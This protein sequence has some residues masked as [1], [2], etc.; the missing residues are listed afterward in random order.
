MARLEMW[1]RGGDVLWDAQV[2]RVVPG[3]FGLS[4]V[5]RWPVAVAYRACSWTLLACDW[6][7]RGA[8]AV[9][10]RGLM[11]WTGTDGWVSRARVIWFRSCARIANSY[12]AIT[13]LWIDRWETGMGTSSIVLEAR[14]IAVALDKF[15][16]CLK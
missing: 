5:T 12:T 6:L 3:G 15:P 14:G 10:G 9:L 11:V 16:S 7:S 2:C 1:A 13:Q 4:M 8:S